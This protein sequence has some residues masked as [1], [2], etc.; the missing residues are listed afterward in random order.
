MPDCASEESR[1]NSDPPAVPTVR[2]AADAAALLAPYFEDGSNGRIAVLHLDPGG[3]VLAIERFPGT[4][5]DAELP[6]REILA[7]AL[8][9]DAARLIVARSRPGG[10]PGPTAGD[11][12][13]TR[14]L[15][16]SARSLGL[17]LAD[18]L[19]F[20]GGGCQSLRELG[21]L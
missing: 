8:R 2:S 4:E 5:D 18:H 10:D 19:I 14:N 1:M 20:A 17:V 16:A 13:A 11:A 21:L 15:A 12:E 9:L 7:G 3:R 6:A